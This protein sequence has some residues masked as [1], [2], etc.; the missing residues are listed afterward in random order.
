MWGEARCP[1]VF[2]TSFQRKTQLDDSSLLRTLI[3]TLPEHVYVKDIEGPYVLNNLAHV[4][5]LGAASPEEVAGSR[6]STSTPKSWQR[7][8]E[9]MSGRSSTRADP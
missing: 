6:T 7:G 1:K 3:D 4:R 2:C 8:T 5:A 9:P